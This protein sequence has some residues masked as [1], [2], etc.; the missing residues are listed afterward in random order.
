[1]VPTETAMIK[2]SHFSVP[3]YPQQPNA[4]IRTSDDRLAKEAQ[5]LLSAGTITTARTMAYVSYY[6]L[7]KPHIHSRLQE[8]LK[9]VMSAYPQQVP[10]LAK[11]ERL[12]YLQALITER[13][14]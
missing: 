8:E 14:R 6:V 10:S 7:T 4:R 3:S 12:P 9:T 1:M 13:L 11:L 5:V 2:G